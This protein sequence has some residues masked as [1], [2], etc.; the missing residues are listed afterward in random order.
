MGNKSKR[1][2][3]HT[4]LKAGPARVAENHADKAKTRARKARH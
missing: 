4:G 2:N 3:L 1:I